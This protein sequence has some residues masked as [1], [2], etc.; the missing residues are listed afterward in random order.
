MPEEEPNTEE[1]R[2][3]Q[4]HKVTEEREL[5]EESVELAEEAQHERRA[6]KAAYLEEKLA[7]REQAERDAD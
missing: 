4:E 2:Q 7:E 5:A 3:T 1:L 6:D